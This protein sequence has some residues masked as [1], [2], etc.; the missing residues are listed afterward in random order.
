MFPCFSSLFAFHLTSN[1]LIDCAQVL[2]AQLL[3]SQ[4]RSEGLTNQLEEVQ[5]LREEKDALSSS[6]A[7]TVDNEKRM[8]DELLKLQDKVEQ[9]K[10]RFLVFK[11][12]GSRVL[13]HFTFHAESNFF[14]WCVCR[15][16][17]LTFW[18][19]MGT[20][21][22]YRINLKNRIICLRRRRP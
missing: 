11:F 13:S 19:P 10:V 20:P 17:K 5:N 4:M 2:E 14:D 15:C 12:I 3:A 6:L 21:R 8:Q 1:Y 7:K 18:W 9:S 22:N 16:L